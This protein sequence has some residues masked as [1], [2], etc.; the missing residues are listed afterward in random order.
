ML[1]KIDISILTYNS[2]RW[3]DTFFESLMN[4][5]YLLKLAL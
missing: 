4:Q 3:I 2:H 5:N 1:N